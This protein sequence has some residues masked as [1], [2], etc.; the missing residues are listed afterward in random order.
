MSDTAEVTALLEELATLIQPATAAPAS[1]TRTG[2]L[3]LNACTRAVFGRTAV[4]AAPLAA[5]AERC[6]RAIEITE[7]LAAAITAPEGTD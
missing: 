4:E 2:I 3:A 1:L 6:T 5:F 7:A